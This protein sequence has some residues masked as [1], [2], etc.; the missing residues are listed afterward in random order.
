[1]G[2]RKDTVR[3]RRE[4]IE[5]EGNGR[6]CWNISEIMCIYARRLVDCSVFSPNIV[7]RARA[8]ARRRRQG[9]EVQRAVSRGLSGTAAV[10]RLFLLPFITG[11]SLISA[12]YR[13]V[14]PS[15]ETVSRLSPAS[16]GQRASRRGGMRNREERKRWSNEG[17]RISDSAQNR[18]TA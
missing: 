15:V 9:R 6:R 3:E 16:K 12:R 18:S 7:L 13:A 4:D 14:S 2:G 1:M 11:S 10:M 8:R 17:A 5:G